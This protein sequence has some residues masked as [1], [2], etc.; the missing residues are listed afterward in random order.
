[1]GS[2]R[3]IDEKQARIL[4]LLLHNSSVKVFQYSTLH[5]NP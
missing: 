1:M 2:P 3:K 5:K 4:F